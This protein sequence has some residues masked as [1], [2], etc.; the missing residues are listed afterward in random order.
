MLVATIITPCPERL[1]DLKRNKTCEE[2]D[3]TEV[4][5]NRAQGDL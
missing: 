4:A 2:A 5:E 1:S 3:W